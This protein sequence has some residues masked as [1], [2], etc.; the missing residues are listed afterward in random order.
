MSGRV[1]RREV[2]GE[3]GW[4]VV[5]HGLRRLNVGNEA[6]K[7]KG[8]GKEI[9]GRVPSQI[10]KD[11][12]G[13]K[14]LGEFGGLRGRWRDTAVARQVEGLVGKRGWSG[15]SA[16]CIGIGSFSRDWENRWRSLWQLVLFI[17]VVEHFGKEGEVKMYAQDPAFIRLDKEF[18]KHLNITTLETGIENYITPDS[19][20]Y[21]PFVDWFVLLPT[22]LATKDP[23]VYVGNE[24]L[25]DYTAYAQTQDK[26][27]KL[28]ECNELGRIFLK[29]RDMVKLND[30]EHHAHALSGMVMY[31]STNEELLP[32]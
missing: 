21:S 27:D 2:E 25:D 32:T 18:L 19:F 10:V 16:V 31:H 20:V 15:K 9:A 6:G 12:T 28:S 29:D 22:F 1:K 30:F 7:K 5:T 3:D 8:T 14:L 13:E 4:R 23:A 26:K 11:V 24:I 17:H